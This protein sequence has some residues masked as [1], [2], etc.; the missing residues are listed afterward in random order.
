MAKPNVSLITSG[1][2]EIKGRTI[3]DKDGN[4]NEVD[5]LV[6]ATGFDIKGFTGNLKSR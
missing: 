2:S 4:E 5:I 3:T 1:I 6:L